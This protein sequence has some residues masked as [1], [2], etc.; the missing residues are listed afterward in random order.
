M[1]LRP[2]QYVGTCLKVTIPNVNQQT[3]KQ[4]PAGISSRTGMGLGRSGARIGFA[5]C[6]AWNASLDSIHYLQTMTKLVPRNLV[7]RSIHHYTL[8]TRTTALES[9]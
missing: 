5:V 8:P 3:R 7:L 2:A 4:F 1:F 9:C 6:A